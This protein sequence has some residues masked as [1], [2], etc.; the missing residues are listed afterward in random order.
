MAS[1]A[2]NIQCLKKDI[3]RQLRVRKR[4]VSLVARLDN[5]VLEDL[6]FGRLESERKEVQQEAHR[7]GD[8]SI[9]TVSI[10]DTDDQVIRVEV[11]EQEHLQHGQEEVEGSDLVPFALHLDLAD[12]ACIKFE[13]G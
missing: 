8:S 6:S 2:R 9:S 12:Q 5:G 3:K 13:V 11:A 7:A 10:R 1:R 4:G